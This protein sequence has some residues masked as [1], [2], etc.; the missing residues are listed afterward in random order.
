MKDFVMTFSRE[1]IMLYFIKILSGQPVK[2]LNQHRP[3]CINVGLV[4]LFGTVGSC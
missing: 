2:Q 4:C 3:R 1:L